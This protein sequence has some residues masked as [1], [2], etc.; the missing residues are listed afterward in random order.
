VKWI[1]IAKPK[2]LSGWELKNIHH[3]GMVFTIKSICRL[4][5]HLGLWKKVMMQKYIEP[6]SLKDWIR[7]PMKPITHASI[8][9]KQLALSYPLLWNWLA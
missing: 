3:F 2:S 4:I 9:W 7:L 8:V 5:N 1:R 6:L